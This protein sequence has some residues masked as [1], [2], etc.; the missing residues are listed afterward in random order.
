[1]KILQFT[2]SPTFPPER[3]GQHRTHGL[4]TE[5]VN[6]NDDV[7]RISQGGDISDYKKLNTKIV[8]NIQTNY[9]EIN[10][11]NPLYDI[12]SL[13]VLF[14]LSHVLLNWSL[15]IYPPRDLAEQIEWAEIIIVEGPWQVRAISQYVNDTPIV[16]SSHNVEFERFGSIQCS[17]VGKWF[18]NKILKSEADA[19]EKSDLV[20]CTSERDLEQYKDEYGLSGDYIVLPN[21]TSKK[22]FQIASN[23]EE[24]ISIRRKYGLKKDDFLAVF[25]GSEYKPNVEGMELLLNQAQSNER[26]NDIEL[27]VIGEVCEHLNS[28]LEN[29][30][31]AGFVD[32]LETH[33]SAGDVYLNPILSGSGTNIKLFDYFA[34]EKPVVTTPFGARGLDLADGEEIILSDIEG[35]IDSIVWVKENPKVADQIAQNAK[36]RAIEKYTWENISK[37]YRKELTNFIE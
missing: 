7:I 30:H 34:R 29:V 11:I 8:N 3:G 16:Y 25:M 23:S 26:W 18:Y 6:K 28:N 1:M 5:F 10:Y 13:P 9:T 33:L 15:S 21:G 12:T 20:V 27:L 31:F 37:K 2:P 22:S 24:V 36:Q 14:D 32:D 19:I 17:M 35:F 4:L